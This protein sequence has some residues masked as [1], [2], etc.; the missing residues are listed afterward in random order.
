MDDTKLAG[1]GVEGI[2]A[3]GGTD[4]ASVEVGYEPAQLLRCV[5]AGID[6]DEDVLNP[7]LF[8][9]EF[10]G[11]AVQHREGGWTDVGTMGV[12][13]ENEGPASLKGTVVEALSGMIDQREGFNGA[14]F[15]EHRGVQ[16]R[17]IGRFPEQL[18][19]EP[20]AAC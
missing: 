2:L 9:F 12:A 13:E 3:A 20:V 17:E 5:P 16:S 19:G 11:H 7:V 1:Q 6:A 4:K 18:I 14:G 8:G 15:F 10:A